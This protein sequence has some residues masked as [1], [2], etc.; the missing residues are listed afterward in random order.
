MKKFIIFFTIFFSVLLISC[1]NNEPSNDNNTNQPIQLN[2]Q[3]T[4]ISNSERLYFN[5][6]FKVKYDETLEEEKVL[7][8]IEGYYRA[9]NK[10]LHLIEKTQEYELN[11][12]SEKNSNLV[13]MLNDKG[14]VS[15]YTE[16]NLIYKPIGSDKYENLVYYNDSSVTT[17]IYLEHL[18]NTKSG[19]QLL[20]IINKNM[21]LSNGTETIKLKELLKLELYSS[22][23][24]ILK[25]YKVNILP[26][27]ENDIILEYSVTNKEIVIK[28]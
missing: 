10:Y 17:L 11:G 6:N 13:Y 15:T 8:N 24:S 20:P 12:I 25:K 27:N 28:Y 23:N 3:I 5:T 4:N 1:N 19:I 26:F 9:E 22:L 2:E 14:K 7:I 21:T 16:N 18:F